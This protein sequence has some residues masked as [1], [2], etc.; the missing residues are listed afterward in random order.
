[1]K[2]KNE[3]YEDGDQLIKFGEH[4][5]A[6]NKQALELNIIAKEGRLYSHLTGTAFEERIDQP[7][8]SEHTYLWEQS[9]PSENKDVYRS[10]YLSYKAIK[11]FKS[12]GLTAFEYTELDEIIQKMAAEDFE[13]SY[14]KGVHDEDA[15]LIGK[16]FFRWNLNWVY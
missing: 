16:K 5:F 4:R 10:E 14:V 7:S 3:L 15:K 11:E 9:I 12:K 13:S 8:L 1:M 6:V 2:D